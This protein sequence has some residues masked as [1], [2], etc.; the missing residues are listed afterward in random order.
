MSFDTSKSQSDNTCLG[1]AF[2]PS[3]PVLH[4]SP[5]TQ[6]PVPGQKEKNNPPW[7][8]CLLQSLAFYLEQAW[9]RQ[10]RSFNFNR[11]KGLFGH[12]TAGF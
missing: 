2:Q 8:N 12:V 10:A 9:A 5:L 1:R 6:K 3:F 7:P 11:L 4:P